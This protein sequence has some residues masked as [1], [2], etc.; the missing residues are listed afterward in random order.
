MEEARQKSQVEHLAKVAALGTEALTAITK[1]AKQLIDRPILPV[2]GAGAS[3]DCGVRLAGEIS[4]ELLRDYKA[5]V[6]YAPH[7]G[8]LTDKDLAGIAEAIHLKTNQVQVVS[9]FALPDETQWKPAPT[10][11][12]HFCSYRLLA[13]MVREGFINTTVGFNYDCG[14]EASLDKEGFVY[15]EVGGGR[16]W[17]D[18]A[19]VVSDARAN[20]ELKQDGAFKLFKA[21]GC[22]T[23]FRE[24]AGAATCDDER[25]AAAEEIVI[26]RSQLDSWRE[27]GWSRDAFRSMA[28]NHVLMLIGFSGQEPKFSFELRDVLTDVYKAHPPDGIPRVVAVDV[29]PDTTAIESLIREGLGKHQLAGEHTDRVRIPLASSTTAAMLVLFSEMVAHCLE[30]SLDAADVTL[31]DNLDVRLATLTVSAPRMLRWSYLVRNPGDNEWIQRANAMAKTGYV[32]LTKFGA[33][34]V[35]LIQCRAELRERLGYSEPESSTEAL[36]NESFVIDRKHGGIAYMPVGIKLKD[37]ES[38]C[39][40]E[41]NLEEMRRMIESLAPTRPDFVLVAEE[42]ANG[43]SLSSGNVVDVG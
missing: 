21:H 37:L 19:R 3:F 30:S 29:N 8:N 36:A 7:D 27:S 15:G 12:E 42:G 23:R 31:G 24:V 6:H 10:L 9:D 34:T 18:H 25:E 17:R 26:R 5:N 43:V 20:A 39:R 1:L 4:K 40:L 13:R 14:V 16:Q 41:E 35:R 22:A 28:R 11:G 2:I 33:D 38:A 32:P